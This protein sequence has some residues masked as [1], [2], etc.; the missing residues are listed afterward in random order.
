MA[1]GKSLSDVDNKLTYILGYRNLYNFAVLFIAYM[2]FL[3]PD[4]VTKAL[5]L[6]LVVLGLKWLLTQVRENLDVVYLNDLASKE[7]KAKKE[8]KSDAT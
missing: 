7:A 6:V 2:A 3:N 1:L 8:M 5:S 4:A